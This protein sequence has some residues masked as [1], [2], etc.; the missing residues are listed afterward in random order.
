M[1][2]ESKSVATEVETNE[3]PEEETGMQNLAPPIEAISKIAIGEMTLPVDMAGGRV[4]T[5]GMMIC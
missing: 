5:L 4:V 2:N 1:D 3:P